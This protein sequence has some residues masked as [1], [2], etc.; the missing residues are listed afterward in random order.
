MK[1]GTPLS[2]SIDCIIYNNH[3]KEFSHLVQYLAI[4]SE[5]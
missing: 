2:T 3:L 1:F 4:V 5:N